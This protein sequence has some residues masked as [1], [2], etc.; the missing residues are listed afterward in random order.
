[1][2]DA[3]LKHHQVGDIVTYEGYTS[4]SIGSGFKCTHRFIISSRCG[5]NIEKISVHPEEREII[6][7]PGAKFKI[8]DRR[9]SKGGKAIEFVMQEVG[10][11]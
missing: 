11:E 8:L 10:C 6:F 4:T 5:R 7:L 9:E 1:M 3:A 2:P